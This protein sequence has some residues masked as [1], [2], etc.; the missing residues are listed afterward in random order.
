MASD[1]VDTSAI[2][3]VALKKSQA[4]IINV[5]LVILLILVLIQAWA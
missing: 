3:E 2:L 5:H 1:E 4:K